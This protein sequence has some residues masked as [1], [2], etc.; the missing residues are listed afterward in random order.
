MDKANHYLPYTPQQPTPQPA[1]R[2]MAAPFDLYSATLMN[3]PLLSSHGAYYVS[4]PMFDKTP[5]PHNLFTVPYPAGIATAGHAFW[6]AY[7]PMLNSTD[8]ADTESVRSSPDQPSAVAWGY[9]PDSAWNQLNLSTAPAPT[10]TQVDPN[11]LYPPNYDPTKRRSSKVEDILNPYDT[12]L[13][14]PLKD[15]FEC[16]FSV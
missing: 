2:A 15:L 6:P 9:H 12:S 7:T 8:Y 1:P 10:T 3:S 4:P 13:L 5:L 11:T 14:P 16:D